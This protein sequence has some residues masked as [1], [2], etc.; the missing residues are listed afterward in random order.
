HHR[1]SPVRDERR[2]GELDGFNVAIHRSL[3][4]TTDCITPLLEEDTG[5][6]YFQYSVSNQAYDI[7]HSP[8]QPQPLSPKPGARGARVIG[9]A[10]FGQGYETQTAVASSSLASR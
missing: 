1:L 8:P 2:R 10:A 6:H 9:C 7:A 3:R 5:S 4:K